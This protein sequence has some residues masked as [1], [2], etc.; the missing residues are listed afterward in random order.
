MWQQGQMTQEEYRGTV[1]AFRESQIPP[2]VQP[3]GNE[4]KRASTDI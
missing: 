4:G 1:Q 2:G 3:G